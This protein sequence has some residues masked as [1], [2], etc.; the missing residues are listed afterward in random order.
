MSHPLIEAMIRE[1]DRARDDSAVR[2][3][4]LT[5]TGRGFCAGAD[6]AGSGPGLVGSD[7]KPDVGIA[8]DRLF[9][10]MIR[11]IRALPKPVVRKALPKQVK[12]EK[13]AKKAVKKP[14]VKAKKV[15]KKP[16]KAR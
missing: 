7:G 1:F 5:G 10:P 13:P 14:A 15:A 6:L 16:Q 8:M 12:V 3:V 9:N 11:A 2:C 4:L